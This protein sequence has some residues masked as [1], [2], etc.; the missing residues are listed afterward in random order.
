MADVVSRILERML[1]EILATERS[2]IF[3]KG[4]VQQIVKE[5]TRYEYVLVRKESKIQDYLR[6]VQYEL[7]LELLKQTRK[8]IR[9]IQRL[10]ALVEHSNV[11]N[12]HTIYRRAVRRHSR[13]IPLWLS[14]IEFCKN[15]KSYSALNTLYSS[16][17][18][19]HPSKSRFWIEAALWEIDHNHNIRAAEVV[20][21]NALRINPTKKKI[22][23]QF[24]KTEV[25]YL[26]KILKR[27]DILEINEE[28]TK[29]YT[30]AKLVK[31]IY[32]QAV[33][34]INDLQ[35]R[36]QFIDV[37][38]NPIILSKKHLISQSNDQPEI[39]FEQKMIKLLNSIK[40]HIYDAT[41]STLSSKPEAYTFCASQFFP[42]STLE[43]PGSSKTL[44]KETEAIS[45]L[46][47]C[48][49]LENSSEIY[50][51]VICFSFDRLNHL[52][53]LF[54][55]SPPDSLPSF[56]SQLLELWKI[57]TLSFIKSFFS[58]STLEV[59]SKIYIIHNRLLWIPYPEEANIQSVIDA[60]IKHIKLGVD[61]I[62]EG[63]KEVFEEYVKR[64]MQGILRTKSQSLI[65]QGIDQIIDEV[66]RWTGKE[67][68]KDKMWGMIMEGILE[69][70]EGKPKNALEERV[71]QEWKQK[72]RAAAPDFHLL[73][74]DKIK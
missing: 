18:K 7:K 40:K 51:I 57:T 15:S 16:A 30:D 21:Q 63:D 52:Y 65:S 13:S 37:V 4:E 33:K 47:N 20:F 62:Y 74:S 49:T 50:S 55:S 48:L 38:L 2:H 43:F 17:V 26:F 70:D 45:M 39:D 10:P 29:Q 32:D 27:F 72:G 54:V 71:H 8:K 41:L 35:F 6:Y 1:P 73:F 28:N 53:S 31:V 66:S 14:Y 69:L 24:F 67:T 11:R 42:V 34:Q 3:T 58:D 9:G 22:Y 23:L 46:K 36:S 25:E 19:V 60:G 59:S 12:I 64:R 5:R 68:G 56:A 61:N 44:Q